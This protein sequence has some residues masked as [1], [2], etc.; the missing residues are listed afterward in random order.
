M[1]L[2]QHQQDRSARAK[3]PQSCFWADFRRGFAEG[4]I[5]VALAA[6]AVGLTA[7]ACVLL[8]RWRGPRSQ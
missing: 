1:T 7:A 4:F 2:H 3:A 6:P 8:S 5:A